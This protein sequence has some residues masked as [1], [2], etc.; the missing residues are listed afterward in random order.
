MVNPLPKHSVYDRM[1][2]NF[3]AKNPVHALYVCMYLGV[4]LANPS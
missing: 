2:G 3:P 4:I 1:Y